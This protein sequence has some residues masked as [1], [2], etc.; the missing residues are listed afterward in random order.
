[1]M[2]DQLLFVL[3]YAHISVSGE[4]LQ[5][6]WSS[7]LDMHITFDLNLTLSYNVCHIKWAAR[8]AQLVA[9]LALHLEVCRLDS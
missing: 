7:G 6:H 9:L 8:L 4:R 5:N 2:V 3:F 1:M